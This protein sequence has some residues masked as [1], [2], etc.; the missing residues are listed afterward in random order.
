MWKLLVCTIAAAVTA[1]M[2]AIRTTYK[3]ALN[4]SSKADKLVEQ[5]ASQ[6]TT[7]GLYRA[8]YGTGLALQAKHSW[9]PATKISKAKNAAT[10]LNQA[11]NAASNNLEVRFLRFSYEVN[12][13]TVVGITKHLATDKAFI[14]ANLNKSNPI[15]STIKSFLLSCSELSSAEKEKVKK[16]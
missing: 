1:D 6:K 3:E 8:Y 14:L 5:T 16:I 4:S 2:A 10:E 13:P 15:W 11:V 9:N 12:V 7:S